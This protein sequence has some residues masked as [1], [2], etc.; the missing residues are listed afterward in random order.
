MIWMAGIKATQSRMAVAEILKAEKNPISIAELR[1]K[2]PLVS[3]ASIYRTLEALVGAGNVNRI[4]TGT[5]H[6][7]YEMAFGRKHH[8]HV[9]CTK[10]GDTEDVET[11]KDCPALKVQHLA[12]AN[13][14][15][16][17]SITEH[18]LEFFGL[19]KKCA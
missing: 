3:T 11:A 2:L 4:N 16:F 12:R 6:A 1:K 14:E 8:H 5:P 19:C 15:K 9:I 17:F 13:S 7:S 18:S 10:C